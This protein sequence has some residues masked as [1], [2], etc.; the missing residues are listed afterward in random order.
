MNDAT[1]PT[2]GTGT[3]F[4]G[5]I[6]TRRQVRVTL[7]ARTLTIDDVEGRLLAEWPYEEIEGLAGPD[8]V[9]RLGR[10]GQVR[11]ERLTIADAA[12]AAAVDARAANVD[13]TGG[14]QH[15]QRLAVVG[16]SFVA[17]A[18]LLLV[19]WF[20]VPAVAARVAPLLP[21][22]VERKL[23]A[24]V[25]MQIR[26]SLDTKHAGTAFECGNGD[27]KADARAAF[28]KVTQRLETAAVLPQ[29]LRFTIV[30]RPESN[31][32][33]IPGGQVYV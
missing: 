1:A 5:R 32:F 33:A 7:G 17:V 8:G 13:R 29:P 30:H 28:A 31:A 27:G 11:L 25:D 4:D 18:T 26:S 19:A 22:S 20:G 12:F 6:S 14:L 21:V 23:G 24:A 10:H 2:S 3:F 15:R 16:L 9:L